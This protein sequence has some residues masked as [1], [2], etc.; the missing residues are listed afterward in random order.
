LALVASGPRCAPWPHGLDGH[1]SLVRSIVEDPSL[2]YRQRVHALALASENLLD[3][4]PVSEACTSAL[5]KGIICDLFEGNAPYRP[6]YT[7]PDYER[8]M[9]QGSRFLELPAPQTFDEATTFLLALYGS[10]PSI[11][12]YPVWFGNIDRL[13]APFAAELDDDE[14][15][16]RLRSI[17]GAARPPVP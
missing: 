16:A 14:L 15:H 2:T 6:R 3:P 12:G 9:R 13:L 17:L 10:V 5:D 8:A 1:R 11:T 7:L 4:P